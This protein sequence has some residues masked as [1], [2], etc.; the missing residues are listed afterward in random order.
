MADKPLIWMGSSL[1]DIRLFPDDA[2]RIAGRQLH[3]VQQGSNPS[4]WKPMPSIGLGIN[5]IR[6]RTG[7][8]HRVVYAA[9]FVEGVYVL[10]VF[11]K[12]TRKTAARDLELARTRWREVLAGRL[13]G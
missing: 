9:K 6:V 1:H 13:K 2:R 12:K 7:R 11:E 5:E 4:D 3:L 8:E 10:H